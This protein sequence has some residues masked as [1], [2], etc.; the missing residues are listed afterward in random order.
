M[1][2]ADRCHMN[3]DREHHLIQYMSR[4]LREREDRARRGNGRDSI[5]PGPEGERERF[6]RFCAR[7]ALSAREREVL[8]QLLEEKTNK[9][10][11][12][13]LSIS[14]GTVKYHIHNLLQK[15][16][17]RNRGVLLSVFFV[18]RD[19]VSEHAASGKAEKNSE[20]Q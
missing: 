10:I 14:E 18:G 5:G 2:Q 11:A 8:R 12:E 9:E 17:C 1:I 6:Y 13:I 20:K 19:H 16:E 15:T 4:G 7:Y 3:P